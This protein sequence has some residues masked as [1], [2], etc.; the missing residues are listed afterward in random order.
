M[1]ALVCRRS[2]S[3]VLVSTR[4]PQFR[5]TQRSRDESSGTKAIGLWLIAASILAT[6][7]ISNFRSQFLPFEIC[8]LRCRDA[9]LLLH[10]RPSIT[11][12][13]FILTAESGVQCI[14]MPPSTLIDWPV[15]KSLS[16]DARKIT[17][18]TRS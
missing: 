1:L 7:G 18:P 4:I 17:V 13:V 14:F 9:A 15:M 8:D 10:A 6:L 2:L 11:L 12:Q 5:V 3:F 16:S